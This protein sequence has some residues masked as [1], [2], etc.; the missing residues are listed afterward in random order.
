MRAVIGSPLRLLTILFAGNAAA[1]TPHLDFT[2]DVR[3]IL[4]RHCFACHGPDAEARKADLSLLDFESA[5]RELAPGIFAVVPGDAEASELWRR[6]IDDEDPMPPRS[7]HDRLDDAERETLKRWIEEGASFSPHWAYVTPARRDRDAAEDTIDE[8]ILQGID[9]AGLEPAPPADRLTL[10]RR[11][12]FDLGG[13][14]PTIGEIDDHLADQDDDAYERLIDRLLESDHFGERFATKWLDLVRYADTVGYHGDQEH[15]AWPYRDW[16]IRAFNRNLPFDRFTIEQLAGDLLP[17]ASQDQLIASG[18]NRLLQTSHEGGLQL[19]E[20]R[21]IYMA[22]RVRNASEVWMGATL[23]CAQCHDHKYDPFTARDFHAFGA[24]FA[25]IDDEEHLRKPY[26]GLNT[27]PT[28]RTP[29]MRVVDDGARQRRATLEAEV[30]LAKRRLDAST[31]SLAEEQP[32]WERELRA[33]LVAGTPTEEIWVDDVLDTG[34]RSQ[35]DWTFQRSEG[36]DPIRGKAYR[37]QA[38]PGLVQ[39]YTVDTARSIAVQPDDRIMAWIHL[40][41]SDPPKSVML[42]VNVE[43]NWEHRAVWGGDQIS[44]GRK[45][46]DHAGYRRMGALPPLD[47]WVRLEVSAGLLGLEPGDEINGIAF[48]QFG[49]VVHWDACS[50]MANAV[51]SAAVIEALDTPRSTRTEEQRQVL[52]DRQ[53]R[54]SSSVLEAQNGLKAALASIAAHDAMLPKTLFTRSLEDP[55]EVRILRRGDWMDDEGEIVQP[56][57]PEFLGV[58][59]HEGRAGRL[60]LARWLVT[61]EAEGGIGELTAR[62]FVNRIWAMLLGEGLCPSV[63]DFGGQGRPPGNLELLDHLALDFIESGWDIKRLVRQIMLSDTYRRSSVTSPRQM[64]VDPDNLVF[65]RQSRHRLSAEAIRDTALS[66]GG[67]LIDRTGG[68]SVKPPQPGGYY[69]HL[70]FPVRKYQATDDENQWRRGVY[71]HWQRQFLHP[72]L[73]AFDAPT[74]EACIARRNESNTPLAALVLMNDPVFLES[75]RG[76]AR[77]LLS[78][79]GLEDAGRLD[80]A[81]RLATTRPARPEEIRILSG[82]LT[83]ARQEVAADPEAA[84]SLLGISATPI[85]KTLDV[86]EFAAWIHVSRTILNLHET[87]NRD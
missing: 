36:L 50:V 38:S 77:R 83:Q 16:V 31:T 7:A 19:M 9:S 52:R 43:G 70:N 69:R 26:D 48:T 13:L 46:E 76:L 81:M 56:A 25:D 29:E 45:P 64:E 15:H 17:D 30:A 82:V 85:P 4:S 27:T 63:E 49:G 59:E 40:D 18:Y 35:G 37:R 62:V 44:Y 60:E 79:E 23:G 57:I 12:S 47:E 65:A 6:I 72:M 28:R 68:P 84:R 58:L 67:L 22:D 87:F 1:E 3:P 74:R 73:K 61:P 75:A 66:V 42:Q 71:V 39:H 5:T 20:Y 34:G 80:L 11:A 8:L 32:A 86:S 55:R 14:P 54:E 53:A 21:A 2:R 51:A 33:R 24:F 10:L 41:P 78:A